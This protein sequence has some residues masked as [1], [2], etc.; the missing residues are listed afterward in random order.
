MQI[1]FVDLSRA[2]EK[3]DP[4]LKDAIQSVV[5]SGWYLLGN[6]LKEFEGILAKYLG[7]YYAVGTANGLDAL[8]IALQCLDIGKGDEVIVPSNTYIASWLAVTRVGATVVPV[9]PDPLS[10]LI[11]ANTIENKITDNTKAIMPVHLYGN[12]CKMTGIMQLADLKSLFVVED[13]A[14]SIGS[15]WRGQ[16]TGSFGHINGNSFYP[17]KNL[18]A[19]GDAGAI[20]SSS[21]VLVEK[22]KA[23]R[24][25]G[26]HKKYVNDY[27]GLNSR[28]DEIHAAV[29]SVK[30]PLLDEWN[31]E[32]NEIAKKYSE[33]LKGVGD[34]LLPHQSE[35][36]YQVWHIYQIRTKYRNSLQK[37]LLDTGIH[38]LIHYPIPPH[39]QKAYRYLGYEKGHFPIA[40]QMA[41]TS[42]SL[43]IYPGLTNEEMDYIIEQII[44]FFEN[45]V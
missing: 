26:S 18:G 3:I 4:E 27:L 2:E 11:E 36:A 32:R 6:K 23:L 7:T 44:Q 38:T 41:Q 33:A 39:L 14:Q 1:P 43:P 34:I 42:L 40:E 5:K 22:A 30:L 10:C 45:A 9:E 17:T 29:L 8:T 15:K 25:Y 31:H 24:N 19:M 37:H 21:E 13:N 12:P 28:L 16:L 35:D 20:S